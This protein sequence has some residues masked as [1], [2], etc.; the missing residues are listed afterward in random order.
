MALPT[1]RQAWDVIL[2][3]LRSGQS[4]PSR[5]PERN[6]FVYGDYDELLN[7][8]YEGLSELGVGANFQEPEKFNPLDLKKPDFD[9]RKA[10]GLTAMQRQIL[11]DP[12]Q[13]KMVVDDMDEKGQPKSL[14]GWS[15]Q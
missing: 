6:P 13:R 14:F 4:L 7:K 12:G 11:S 5:L 8:P 9:A 1:G 15:V 3:R 2:N 10:A